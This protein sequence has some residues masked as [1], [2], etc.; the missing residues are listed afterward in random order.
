VA[1]LHIAIPFSGKLLVVDVYPST[2]GP[3]E[4][5]PSLFVVQSSPNTFG[6]VV[7]G[8]VGEALFEDLAFP[9]DGPGFARFSFIEE[10]IRVGTKA[11]STFFPF[12]HRG[13]LL[14]TYDEMVDL[15]VDSEKF[16][17]VVAGCRR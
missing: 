6:G 7:V 10:D 11:G 16:L 8:D 9:A 5:S 17:K 4:P 12:V 13:N 14:S 3:R 1:Q 15:P 2:F